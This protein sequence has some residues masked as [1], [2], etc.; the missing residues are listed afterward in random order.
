MACLLSYLSRNFFSCFIKKRGDSQGTYATPQ[1]KA[2]AGS[3]E[4]TTCHRQADFP[5]ADQ[6]SRLAVRNI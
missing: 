4:D 6:Y 5:V 1:S 3:A 2:N